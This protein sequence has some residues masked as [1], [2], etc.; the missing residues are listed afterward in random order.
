[1]AD[2]PPTPPRT[3]DRAAANSRP[4]GHGDATARPEEDDNLLESLGK[5]IVD[6]VLTAQPETPADEAH[7]RRH[8]H[9]K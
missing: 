6:P 9:D 5:A 3:T 2:K 7:E 1:M 8:R 4:D